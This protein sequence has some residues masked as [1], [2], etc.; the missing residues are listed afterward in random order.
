VEG[1]ASLD[2]LNDLRV[3]V[4]D[5]LRGIHV[6]ELEVIKKRISYATGKHISHLSFYYLFVLISY[7]IMFN[8]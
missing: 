1:K 7:L 5:P 8:F 4:Y 2:Q 3:K 6:D